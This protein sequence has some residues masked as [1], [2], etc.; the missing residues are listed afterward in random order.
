[1]IHVVVMGNGKEA[2]F[3]VEVRNDGHLIERSVDVFASQIH[4]LA[5]LTYQDTG[6]RKL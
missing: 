3:V 6:Y 4:L 5:Q 2:S 1:M